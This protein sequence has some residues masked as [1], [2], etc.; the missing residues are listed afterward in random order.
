MRIILILKLFSCKFSAC[1]S[2]LPF[3]EKTFTASTIKGKFRLYPILTTVLITAVCIFG[4]NYLISIVDMGIVSLTGNPLAGV[5][6]PTSV[7]GYIVVI[8]SFAIVPAIVEELIY[9]GVVF[10]GLN[11]TYKPAVSILLSALIFALMHFGVHQFVYQFIMGVILAAL[12]Y[13]T[14]SI[15]YGIIFHMINNLTVVSLS[16]FAPNIFT[17]NN[18]NALKIALIIIGALLAIG[19]IIGLFVLLYRLIKKYP[20]HAEIPEEKSEK[21]QLL[22][23]SQGLSEYDIRQLNP[24]KIKDKTL[25]IILT[26][27][28]TVLWL[29]Q[30]FA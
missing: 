11:K 3:T 29:A 14:G 19:V 6:V 25:L 8:I 2:I 23:N 20:T 9:R 21:E 5:E 16:Y 13:F 27:T 17:V 10:N 22:E 30:I 7:I 1:C 4:F 28:I 18:I 12:T 24:T 26:I 15:L